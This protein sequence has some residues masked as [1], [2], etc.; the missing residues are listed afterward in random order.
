[1]VRRLKHPGSRLCPPAAVV[2]DTALASPRNPMYPAGVI[3][4]GSWTSSTTLSGYYGS[5]Y[6]QDGDT[7]PKPELRSG[8]GGNRVTE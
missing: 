2:D 1:M 8:R 6:L 4:T 5:D 7:A 3:T